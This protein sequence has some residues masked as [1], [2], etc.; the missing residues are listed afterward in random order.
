MDR[1][2]SLLLLGS[3]IPEA[4]TG[5]VVLPEV[6][7]KSILYLGKQSPKKVKEAKKAFIWAQV[8]NK[9]SFNGKCYGPGNWVQV[10]QGLL[11][12]LVKSGY[13]RLP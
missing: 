8:T 6:D 5:N 3:T 4:L 13:F 7:E 11:S 12:P 2:E 9:F 10:S 1:R